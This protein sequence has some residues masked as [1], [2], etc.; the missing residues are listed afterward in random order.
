MSALRTV[1]LC[2]WL[3]TLPAQSEPAPSATNNV[4]VPG[5]SHARLEQVRSACIARR[6]RVCGRVLQ[7]TPSGLVVDSGYASLLQPPFNHSWLTPASAAPAPPA[8]SVEA[9]APDSIAI[10]LVFL[11][12]IPK[13]QKVHEYDY[14]ALI[15]YPAG[16]FD[17]IPAPGVKKSIRRFAAGLESAVAFTIQEG[18]H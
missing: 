4:P 15:S 3:A 5:P 8:A 9:T 12:D 17:Y 7:V 1:W 18:E 13:R 16:H 11:T 6:H 14:V 10:G 2:A